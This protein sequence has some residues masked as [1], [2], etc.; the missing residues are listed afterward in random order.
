[1]SQWALPIGNLWNTDA[2]WAQ[3][4][5]NGDDDADWFDELDEGFGAG[6]GSGSG[7]DDVTTQWDTGVDAGGTFATT[8]S[9]GTQLSSVTDPAVSTG[10]VFRTRNR[11]T[12]AAGQQ[13]DIY[14]TLRETGSNTEIATQS[15]ID[16]D[17]SWTTRGK[18]LSAS[19]A[20]SITDYGDLR[21]GTYNDE[22]GGGQ[23]RSTHESAHEFE[24]PDASA[25]PPASLPHQR[26]RR[27]M[28]LLGR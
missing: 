14:S 18:T 13:V 16:V 10:H 9:I 20:D 11:K 15:E 4:T 23:P 26:G 6:R 24:C 2:E 27:M 3:N 8:N 19:E 21:I 17:G 7:P 25:G 1:M 28:P 22:V 12:V 5:T